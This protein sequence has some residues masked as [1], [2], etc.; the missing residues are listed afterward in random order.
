MNKILR[1]RRNLA[2][3]VVDI[4]F[5]TLLLPTAN[6]APEQT[7]VTECYCLKQ[8]KSGLRNPVHMEATTLDRKDVFLI[9]EQRGIIHKF[10]PKTGDLEVYIDLRDE[11][12]SSPDPFDE[13]GLLGFAVHPNFSSNKQL[14]TYSIR[15]VSGQDYVAVSAITDKN[16]AEEKL[17]LMIKQPGSR[18]N[19]GQVWFYIL[20]ANMIVSICI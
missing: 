12:V 11:I 15:G 8:L 7:N 20:S 6:A 1:H 14:Y 2:E 10:D 5:L 13:R 4:I 18:R 9:G 16:L 17:L 3:V 19:G